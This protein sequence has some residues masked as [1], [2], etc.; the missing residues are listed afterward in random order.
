MILRTV[1]DSS[2][3]GFLFFQEGFFYFRIGSGAML[4]C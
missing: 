1:F 4:A 2:V 3:S